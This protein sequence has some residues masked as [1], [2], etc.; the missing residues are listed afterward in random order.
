MNNKPG[1]M[2]CGT[3]I[4]EVTRIAGERG[5]ESLEVIPLPCDF[6]CRPGPG[7]RNDAEIPSWI[8]GFGPILLLGASCLPDIPDVS[9][10]I[11]ITRIDNC[12]EILLP[13]ELASW[14]VNNGAYFITPGWLQHWEEHIARWGFDTATAGPFFSEWCSRIVLLDTGT[15]PESPGKLSAFAAFA[16]RPFEVLPAGLDML[17]LRMSNFLMQAGKA[18]EGDPGGTSG[19]RSADYAMAF[20]MLSRLSGFNTEEQVIRAIFE[21]FDML[22]APG[23]QGYLPLHKGTGTAVRTYPAMENI[24]E[25]NRKEMNELREPFG[26]TGSK[27]GFL[28]RLDRDGETFGVLLIDNLAFPE[29]RDHYLNLAL[30]IVPVLSLAIFNARMFERLE[31]TNQALAESNRLARDMA[32]KAEAA[33]QAKSRFLANMSHEVRT[34]MNG[35]LGMAGL[36][37]D[38]PLTDE[39]RNYTEIIRSSG[40]ALLTIINDI[41]DF[42]KNL[43]ICNN[44][45]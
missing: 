30:S 23:I 1:V 25:A 28:L 31:M 38:T 4:Q 11:R 15:D 8:H 35:V 17:R 22:A 12:S 10:G 16:D 6:Y 5:F 29:K 27:T 34:P 24:P 32:V 45:V 9:G 26:L 18:P 43:H 44:E 36:L 39:Q 14:Y 37:L 40:D 41:L 3:L 7:R 2:V 33:S 42:S 21:L 13:G 19:D 20:D